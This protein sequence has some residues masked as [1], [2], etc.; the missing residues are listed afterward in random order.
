MWFLKL[1]V[2]DRLKVESNEKRFWWNRCLGKKWKI[3]WF[4]FVV[5]VNYGLVFLVVELKKDF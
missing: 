1:N 2:I 4:I 5:F 3:K